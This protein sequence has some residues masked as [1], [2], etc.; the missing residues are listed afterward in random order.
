MKIEPI[1]I[2]AKKDS[3]VF[4]L[5]FWFLIIGMVPLIIFTY[6]TYTQD[7]N[8]LNNKA[9]EEL[10]TDIT[11]HINFI[12]DWF[13]YRLSDIS[14]WANTNNTINFFTKLKELKQNSPEGEAYNQSYEFAL[15]TDK[16]E[17]D[18]HIILNRYDYVN[19]FLLVDL[20]GEVL[21]NVNRNNDY[22]TL[23]LEQTQLYPKLSAGFTTTKK[24]GEVYF[25]DLQKNLGKTSAYISAPIINADG[26]FIAVF[27]VQIYPKYF[28]NTIRDNSEETHLYLVGK[29]NTLRNQISLNLTALEYTL[30]IPEFTV[31][32]N[33][34]K[35][36]KHL[37]Y[38][39]S[40]LSYTNPKGDFVIGTFKPI[41]LLGQ[42]WFIISEIS[43]KSI[44]VGKDDLLKKLIFLSLLTLASI[45][46][47]SIFLAKKLTQP[48]RELT[49]VSRLFRQGKGSIDDIPKSKGEVGALAEAFHQMILSLKANEN[50]LKQLTDSLEERV[51]QEVEQ[52][53]KK[54]RILLAH[55]RIAEAK[56]NHSMKL[57]GENVISSNSDLK[58]IITYASPALCE[59]SGYSQEELIGQPHS[60]LRHPDTD[61]KIFKEMWESIQ[62]GKPWYGELKNIKKNGSYYWIKVSVLPDLDTNNK[63][64]SYTA[65]R[66]D[67]TPEKVKEEFLANMSHELRTPLN[68]IIGFSGILNK[69]SKDSFHLELSQQI[70]ASSKSLLRLI[71]DIL[72]LS[73]INSSSFSIEPFEFNAYQEISTY[74]KS[75]EGLTHEKEIEFKAII[76]KNLH[77]IF[78]GDWLRISQVI[79]NII[80]NSIKFTPKFGKI[81][82]S[83]SYVKSSLIINITDNG[84]GMNQETQNKIFK[85]FTQADGTTTRK[86]GGTGLGLNITQ[87]LVEAMNG[88]IELQSQEGKGSTFKVTI[89]LTKIRDLTAQD[90]ECEP[91]EDDESTTLSGHI[92]VAEDNKTNQ[93]LI[94]MLLEEQNISCDIANDG[95]EA[96][97]IYDPSKHQ[98]ILMDENMPNMNGIIAMQKIKEK[99]GDK[100]GA[101]IALT[102]NNME[103]DKERFLKEGMDSFISKP[104]DEEI[105]H[106]V[107]KKFLS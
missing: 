79:L 20:D 105:L 101:I 59:I 50:H 76:D 88:K 55:S 102:A 25:S 68:A 82:Y 52:N 60:I 67:I 38:E 5:F 48:I 91:F 90:K 33:S 42:E 106:K 45:I 66:H 43:Y 39:T 75:F 17:S 77:A 19:D 3:F 28:I 6:T 73:K 8:R 2:I 12:N 83:L 70:N 100:C 107:L 96:L 27:I 63:V 69:K 64:L 56:L 35:K 31:W 11:E 1:Q 13:K 21:Y 14:L 84:I 103:G 44:Y 62:A 94:Q 61:A 87:N 104:I 30:D 22:E 10:Y 72:D 34:L 93:M 97:E 54:D 65:I 85:P 7:I 36:D 32:K 46:V 9:K 58:G 4:I 15:I 26:D 41:N 92:L 53:S 74:T 47:L 18:L 16:Y 51:S 57:F 40:F 86:Y 89:P 80:S 81:L 29:D 95:L 49:A 98:L 23:N 78:L 24:S 71:N 37:Q 99:Y